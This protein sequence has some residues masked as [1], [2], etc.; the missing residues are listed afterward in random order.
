MSTP[1]SDSLARKYAELQ[2]HLAR[3]TALQQQFI[4]V[5]DRLDRELARFAAIHGHNTRAMAAHDL[6]QFAETTAESV[7]EIFELE[8]GL[9]WLVDER[10]ELDGQPACAVGIGAE[11]IERAQVVAWRDAL[12]RAGNEAVLA[13]DAELAL[14]GG[15]L[16]QLV[17]GRCSGPTGRLR[18]VLVGGITRE[19]G[20]FYDG[21]THDHLESFS[22]FSQQVGALLQNRLDQAALREAE[23]LQ[24]R[25]REQAEAASRAKSEFLAAMSHE[26]RTPMNGVLGM[27]QL[28]RDGSLDAEHASYVD[29]A[30]RSAVAL[31]GIIDDILDLSK[32]E[33]GKLVLE[34]V[35]F[36][37]VRIVSDVLQLHGE[38]ARRKGLA[39]TLVVQEGPVPI[40]R[41]DPGRLRQIVTN[42]VGNAVKFTAQGSITITASWTELGDD[43][44]RFELRVHDTGIGIA[45]EARARLFT[46]FTQADASTTRR[47]GGTGLGLAI[48]RRLLGL[49]DG[50][51]DV[52][53]EPGRGSTFRFD[54]C[55]PLAS[56]R[57]AASDPE[58]PRAG[59]QSL[60]LDRRILLVEDNEIN[61]VVVVATLRRLGLT[62][63]VAED[64]QRALELLAESRFDLVIMDVQM[65]VMD[66]Y[67]TTRR[68]RG[69]E[70][71]NGWTRTPV[72]AMTANAMVQDQEDCLESGM[73]DF[74]PKPFKRELLE[75]VLLRW[76]APERTLGRSPTPDRAS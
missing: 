59:Q 34:E 62:V 55:H 24:R 14:A 63:V 65:P 76:L 38:Q 40:V 25:A 12:E 35:P 15:L 49:M 36:Q 60:E 44:V 10:G 23:Q 51:I 2:Q 68:L 72:M 1:D 58:R 54:V 73:D 13:S 67:E 31:L 17:I 5:R 30:H 46:P 37:P 16:R 11:R 7:V 20:D 8:L 9:L 71:A 61:Q 3:F 28:L 48:C 43:Q 33:A 4:G 22:V 29:V 50:T 64:G 42:L 57:Q 52:E 56:R 26:I 74:I 45:P 53:S 41:G 27:L 19:G 39:L 47:F 75:D 66:G 32:I 69:M 70:R 18:G 6:A 21:M